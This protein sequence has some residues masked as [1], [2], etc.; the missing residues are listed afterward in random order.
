MITAKQ[1][2]QTSPQFK[3]FQTLLASPAFEPACNAALL[4]LIESMPMSV[5]DP[6][7][8]WDC[9]GQIVGARLVLAKLSQLHLRDEELK[10]EPPAWKYPKP[11][12]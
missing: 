1:L 2:F 11:K 12:G 3:D 6:S 9:Y 4:D 5:G 8:A 10:P 7:K